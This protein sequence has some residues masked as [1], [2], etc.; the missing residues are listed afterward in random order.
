[1]SIRNITTL[2]SSVIGIDSMDAKTENQCL[3]YKNKKLY[4]GTCIY[5]T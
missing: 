3:Q 1:M 2:R 4:R 5:V